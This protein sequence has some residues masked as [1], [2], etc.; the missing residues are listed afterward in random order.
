MAASC[1]GTHGASTEPAARIPEPRD[2]IHTTFIPLYCYNGFILLLAIVANVSLCLIYKLSLIG[3]C[4]QE[5]TQCIWGVALSVR[6]LRHPLWALGVSPVG[7]APVTLHWSPT[8]LL[9]SRVPVA[10]FPLQWQG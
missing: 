6:G 9:V 2:R 3:M 1:P 5:K 10:A 4:V 7:G 8:L